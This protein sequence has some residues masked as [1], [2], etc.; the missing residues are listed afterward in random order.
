MDEARKISGKQRKKLAKGGQAMKDGSFPIAN[1]Q[2][3]RNAI[4]AYGRAS[5][6]AAAKRHIIKRARALGATNLLPDD[7]KN[8][9]SAMA[10]TAEGIVT[11]PHKFSPQP[12]KPSLCASCNKSRSAGPHTKATDSAES[13]HDTMAAL[14]RAVRKEVGRR[15]Y[16]VDAGPDWVVYERYDE[17][18]SEYLFMRRSYTG[19]GASITLG[20][21]ATE[22]L[23]TTVYVPVAKQDNAA[24]LVEIWGATLATPNAQPPRE[25]E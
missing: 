1:K 24:G 3:L 18:A 6:K 11:K 9:D 23:R 14:R 12:D 25:A 4:Q 21:D 13:F 5:N 22:V 2:D 17:D 15:A 20:D 8:G 16:L 7:W 19:E 10:E